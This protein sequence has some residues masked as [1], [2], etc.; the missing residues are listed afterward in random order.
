MTIK[1]FFTG[2]FMALIGVIVTAFSQVPI[3]WALTGITALAIVLGYTGGNLA[4]FFP[5]TSEPSKFNWVD[6]GCALLIALSTGITEYIGFIV[7]GQT[8]VWHVLLSV[9]G[10]VTLTFVAATFFS[11]PKIQS[12]KISLFHKLAA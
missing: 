6:L 1:T 4:G 5:S 10:N 8:V 2:L 9:V 11:P 3:N 12:R 7:I